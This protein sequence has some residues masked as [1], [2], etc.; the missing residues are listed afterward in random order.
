[1][2]LR[3]ADQEPDNLQVQQDVADVLRRLGDRPGALRQLRRAIDRAAVGI[4]SIQ[5]ND[6]RQQVVS[7]MRSSVAHMTKRYEAATYFGYQALGAPNS[8]IDRA[9]APLLLSQGGIELARYLAGPD[10]GV[11]LIGRVMTVGQSELSGPGLRDALSQMAV[12]IRYKPFASE[13]LNFSGERLFQLGG[14]WPA[15]WLARALYA[16]EVGGDVRP[17]E[18]WHP[19]SLVYGDLAGFLGTYRSLLAYGE[20]RVGAS[21]GLSNSWVVRPHIVAMGRRDFVGAAGDAL[22]VGVGLGITHYFRDNGD[23]GP[24]PSL[25]LRL[26]GSAADARPFAIDLLNGVKGLTV[27]TTLRF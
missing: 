3:V 11:A 18:Q 24:A 13:N 27:V 14:D 23:V 20:A 8:V 4:G 16:K 26:Y 17:D 25:E 7:R 1:M 12:G 2:L 19:Y 6:N 15:S 22:L 21:W 9:A 5:G 10:Q